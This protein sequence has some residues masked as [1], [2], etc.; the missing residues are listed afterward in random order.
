[1]Q[2]VDET[3]RSVTVNLQYNR[4]TALNLVPP[5]G[6]LPSVADTSKLDVSLLWRPMQRLR[7]DNTYLNSRLDTKAGIA[8]FQN[9][10]VRSSWNYQFT[11]EI[12]LRLIAQHE[13]TDAGPATRLADSRN[14]NFDVLLR[15]VINP[16]SA[17]YVGYNRNARNFE[18][19]ETAMGRELVAADALTKD[20]E[21]VF[22]K[23]S[24]LFQR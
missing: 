11:K 18:I 2:I 14:L 3:L 5:A 23:L 24:Y 16:L 15:Y 12:S 22:V 4:G 20:G 21:Q 1:V 8:V 19:I 10:I 6:T 17:F 7:V 13:K 9:R